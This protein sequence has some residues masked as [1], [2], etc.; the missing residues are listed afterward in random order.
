M[1][2]FFKFSRGR[3]PSY[4]MYACIDGK[5]LQTFQNALKTSAD[6]SKASENIFK[7]Y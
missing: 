5:R 3:Y 7:M 4:Y 2:L 6:V 1:V